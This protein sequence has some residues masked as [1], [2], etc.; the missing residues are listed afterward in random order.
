VAPKRLWKPSSL[1]IYPG[2]IGRELEG[3]PEDRATASCV[4]QA[5][6]TLV[7]LDERSADVQ[8]ESQAD[9]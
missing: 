7:L 5:D 6:T 2:G 8:S 3:E 1:S 4:A 9:A